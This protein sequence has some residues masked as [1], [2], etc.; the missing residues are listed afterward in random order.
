LA[1]RFGAKAFSDVEAMLAAGVDSVHVL[2]PPAAH[3]AAARRLLEGGVH[4]LLE[5]PMCL[6]PAECAELADLARRRGR[7]VGVSH[8][9]LFYPIYERLKADA[10]GGR[11]GRVEHVEIVWNKELGQLRAGPFGG[12]PFREPGDVILEVGPHSVAH[13]LD[14]LGRP[15]RVR[16]EAGDPVELPNGVPFCRRWLVRAEAGRAVADL[17]FAFGPGFPEHFI[18]VRGTAGSATA[19][20]ERGTY[21][22]RR[23]G[24]RAVDFDR[25]ALAARESREIKRQTRGALARYVLSKFGLSREGNP[26]GASIARALKSFY[27]GLPAPGD[28][29]LSAAFGGDVVGTRRQIIEA[30][31]LPP[32]PAAA[33][34]PT[35]PS[36]PPTILVLGGTGFIGRALVRRLTE[37]GRSV[38]LAARDPGSLPKALRGLPLDVAG[39][40]LADPA[41]LDAA[42]DGIETVYHLARGHGKTWDDYLRL[43]VGVTRRVAEACLRRGVRRLVYT[44]AIDSYY[45]GSPREVIDERTPL[46]PKIRRRNLYAL[47]KAESERLLL[48]LHRERGLPVTIFRPGVVVG[49]S[50]S[51]YHWGVGFWPSP[52]VCLLWGDGAHPLPLVLVEDAARA[53]ARAAEV[54]GLAGESFNLVSDPCL[55]AREYVAEVEW[56]SGVSIDVRPTAA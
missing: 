17:R 28:A 35:R 52:S 12:W 47:A 49:S 56:A 29:R 40:D 44:G 13:L 32:A 6:R 2:L 14:L 4:V 50:A 7:A 36:S 26:F 22:L 21:V 41:A 18:H 43:D 37:A 25:Y 3:Y 30:A 5:K 55:S 23:P 51:P 33:P 38:R 53:L 27:G 19:D 39:G 11:L 20:F 1:G 15:D 48:E 24:A 42:L 16:A 54:D 8:N 31:G 46:D 10:A 9:F 45:S 34:A